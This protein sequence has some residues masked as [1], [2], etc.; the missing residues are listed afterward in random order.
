METKIKNRIFLSVIILLTLFFGIFIKNTVLSAI[1]VF[2]VL[3][4]G[5]MKWIFS[6]NKKSFHII[7]AVFHILFIGAFAWAGFTKSGYIPN[8]LNIEIL[9]PEENQSQQ[10]NRIYYNDDD[11]GPLSIPRKPVIYLYS[12]EKTNV[13]VKLDFKGKIIADYPK[14]NNDIKGWKITAH[15]D[16]RIIGS[17]NQ[18]YSYLFWEGESNNP[19]DWDLSKGFVVK[20]E[21][22]R[23]FLQKILSN[24]GLT[25]KEYNEFIVYWYPKMK[26]NP[27]NLIHF[28]GDQYTQTAPL[29]ITPKPD[30]ILRVFMVFKSLKEKIEIEPQ[31]FKLFERKGFTVVEWGGEEVE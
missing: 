10:D 2:A 29:E 8:F 22:T 7:M 11:Y 14:Y 16:G 23:E 27:Y 17:D 12:R 20:G 21:D 3:A 6:K 9:C 5:I 4:A 1:L 25:P 30:L 26:N 28:A 19:V 18:E 13:T 24:I 31:K 15:P